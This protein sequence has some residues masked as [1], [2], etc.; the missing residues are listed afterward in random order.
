MSGAVKS[1]GRTVSSAVSG[2]V[3]GV[4]DLMGGKRPPKQPPTEYEKELGRQSVEKWNR[5]VDRYAPLE[6][7][8]L[9]E[10]GRSRQGR[11][12]AHTNA[13]LMSEATDNAMAALGSSGVTNAVRNLGGINSALSMAGSMGHTQSIVADRA[14]RDD[15]KFAAMQRG[16]GIAGNQTQALSALG[17]EQTA[18]SLQR[19]Q[20]SN[21]ARMDRRNAVIG[22]VNSMAQMAAGQS[23]ENQAIRAQDQRLG[24]ALY[25]TQYGHRSDFMG[26][27]DG[28]VQLR[29]R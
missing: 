2:V 25:Q 26:H 20:I 22:S 11:M 4:G 27:M 24:G 29:R 9:A 16:M 7:Q 19:Y 1:V 15:N 6:E 3:G 21:Q 13:Q 28:Q 23:I 10:L 17:R 14:E 8:E 5:Y 12:A 18:Q